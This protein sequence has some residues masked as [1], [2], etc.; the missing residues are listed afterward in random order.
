MD[1]RTITRF[2]GMQKTNY[3]IPIPRYGVMKLHTALFDGEQ[4]QEYALH[5]WGIK[6]IREPTIKLLSTYVDGS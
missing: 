6:C 5:H 1:V 2:D 4:N 3:F